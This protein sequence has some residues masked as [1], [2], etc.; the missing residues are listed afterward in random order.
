MEDEEQA[1]RDDRYTSRRFHYPA[2]ETRRQE[3]IAGLCE[4]SRG[5]RYSRTS[6]CALRYRSFPYGRAPCD[7]KAE[8]GLFCARTTLGVDIRSTQRPCTHEDSEIQLKY[9]TQVTIL[10]DCPLR[11]IF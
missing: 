2:N 4:R 8:R 10:D 6:P 5:A 3:Y 1:R 9:I 11:R 7:P